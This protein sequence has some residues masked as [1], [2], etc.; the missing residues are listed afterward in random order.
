ML[1]PGF[2]TMPVTVWLSASHPACL[3]TFSKS[4]LS[5]AASGSFGGIANQT[6]RTAPCSPPSTDRI[7]ARSLSLRCRPAGAA[8]VPVPPGRDPAEDGSRSGALHATRPRNTTAPLSAARM[9]GVS[10]VSAPGTPV[11]GLWNAQPRA[12]HRRAAERVEQHQRMEIAAA[13]AEL[14]QPEIFP[15]RALQP[16]HPEDP[17]EDQT[18][19]DGRSLVVLHL[20]R[21]T[22][23]RRRG[24]VVP[25]P[26]AHAAAH[27]RTQHQRVP[28]PPHSEREP[29]DGRGYAEG[30]DVGE[31]VEI[32]AER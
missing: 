2:S 20:P 8:A 5:A 19:R 31:R 15:H 10:T 26:T 11:S 6:L 17:D 25:G 29:Q 1:R 23:E 21:P 13:Q 30:H 12:D 22:R 32:R 4:F 14:A 24:D 16:R 27:E 7:A 28:Y 3:K 9:G 18:G